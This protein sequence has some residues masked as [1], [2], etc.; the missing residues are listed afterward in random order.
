MTIEDIRNRHSVRTFTNKEI[1]QSIINTIKAEITMVNTIEAGLHFQLISDDKSPFTNFRHSYGMFR[2]ASNYIACVIE[3]SYPNTYQRCGYCAQQIVLKI[4]SLGLG[5][6]YVG[7]TYNPS[8]VNAQLRAGEKIAFLILFG[9]EDNQ[10][11]SLM[12]KIGYALTHRNKRKFS[13]YIQSDLTIDQIKE[14][15]P[16]LYNAIEAVALAPSAL[17][18][19]PYKIV[20]NDNQI[21][22]VANSDSSRDLID[23][24]IAMHNFQI[25]YPGIWEWGNPA[26]FYPDNEI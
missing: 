23:L 19:Q 5:T 24:G 9:Y 21:S 2:N 11:K 25:A 13:E 3:P 7:G 16:E 1:E 17:N 15:K 18:R 10:S 22:A 14:E 4:V 12:S 6:C 26:Y 20:L 8:K